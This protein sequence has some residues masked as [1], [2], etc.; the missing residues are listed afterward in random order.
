MI[1]IHFSAWLYFLLNATYILR[2]NSFSLSLII[3]H[4]NFILLNVLVLNI[5]NWMIKRK[6]CII[7]IIKVLLTFSLHIKL[8]RRTDE[9]DWSLIS[10]RIIVHGII[11]HILLWSQYY[12]SS[13]HVFINKFH[14]FVLF[15]F[16]VLKWLLIC[17][18]KFLMHIHWICSSLLIL[19]CVEIT[20]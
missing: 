10:L 14:F 8:V 13:L 15:I 5:I 19:T 16:L 12:S 18:R 17:L 4:L 3:I 20:V 9:I 1:V 2:L 7:L 11:H 6:V